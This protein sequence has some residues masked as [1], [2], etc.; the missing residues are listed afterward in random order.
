MT[1][2]VEE[3]EERLF[4]AE[5]ELK[6]LLLR[7]GDFVAEREGYMT[8]KGLSAIHYYLVQ[9]YHWT[10]AQV[11]SML[12]EDIQFVLDEEIHGWTV[13]DEISV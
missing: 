12:A 3:I 4:N 2:A 13:P 10:P 9:K 6:Y 8:H 1:R 5:G 7:F 11:R